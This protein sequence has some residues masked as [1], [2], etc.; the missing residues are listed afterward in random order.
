MMLASSIDFYII[1]IK[2]LANILT[3]NLAVLILY[4]VLCHSSQKKRPTFWP[5]LRLH[6]VTN[7]LTFLLTILGTAQTDPYSELICQ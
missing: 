3:H 5:L 7:A 4:N 1:C 6:T 2:N